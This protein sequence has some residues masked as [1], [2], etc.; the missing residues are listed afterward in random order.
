M[1]PIAEGKSPSIA[2]LQR[3]VR[4]KTILEFSLINNTTITGSLKWFDETAF[5]IICQDK[6]TFTI[7]RSHI[8]GYSPVSG[9][10][11]D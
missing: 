10:K 4:E 2:E 3:F 11:A 1:K 8:I 6:P 5:C 7:Q 9:N